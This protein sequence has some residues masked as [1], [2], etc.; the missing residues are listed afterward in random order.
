MGTASSFLD[1]RDARRRGYEPIPRH[2]EDEKDMSIAY[3]EQKNILEQMSIPRRDEERKKAEDD[4]SQQQQQEQEDIILFEEERQGPA[5]LEARARVLRGR[6]FRQGT[7]FETWQDLKDSA[8]CYLIALNWREAALAFAE[9]ALYDI[10]L[11][12]EPRAA[13][14][15]LRSAKCFI[16]IEHKPKYEVEYVEQALEEATT[17]FARTGDLQ[18]AAT[19]CLELAEFYMDQQDLQGALR[20]FRRAAGYC[21]YKH[22]N[23]GHK[24]DVVGSLLRDEEALR[25]RG[26][27]PLEDYKRR[28]AGYIRSSDPDWRSKVCDLFLSTTPPVHVAVSVTVD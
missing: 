5:A 26:V 17:L 22:R 13:T 6:A 14:A 20:T 23:C 16:E 9:Q 12:D 4:R 18:L 21:G 24:A 8:L 25:R 10:Q 27:L 15:L 28:S 19:S 3:E 2:D 1:R 7:V 11:G